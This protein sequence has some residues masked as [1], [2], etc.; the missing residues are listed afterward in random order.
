MCGIAG[1]AG[2]GA[3]A[4]SAQLGDM[5][6]ALARRGPDGEGAHGW[7]DALLGHRRLAIFDLTDAGR[8]PMLSPDGR[9]GVTFNGAIYNFPQLRAQLIERGYTFTSRTDTEVLVHG[10]DAWGIDALVDRLHGMFA[11]ALWDDRSRTLHLVRDRLGVK[12]LLYTQTGQ[13]LAFA[14]TATA[15]AA[16]RLATDLDAQGIAEFLEFSFVSDEHS[17]YHNVKKLPAAH[18]A[19]WSDGVLSLRKYWTPSAHQDSDA[20][21]EEAVQETEKIFLRAVQLRLEADVPVAAL[22]SGGIDSSLVCWGIKALG[23]DVTAYTIATPADPWDESGDAIQTAR[24]IGIAH[25]VLPLS[26]ENAPEIGDL[27]CAYGEPFACGSALG[28]LAISKLVREHAKVLLT[29]DGG[30]DVFLGYPRD[31][32]YYFAQRMAG[33]LPPQTAALWTSLRRALPG[34]G[35]LR[36]AMHFLDYATGGYPAV[37]A[38]REGLPFY[39]EHGMLGERLRD[40]QLPHRLLAPS[41]Q[42]ARRIMADHLDFEMRTSF[43]SEYMAK[44]DG[45][46]MYHALE[47]RSPMLDQR[48]WEY[49]SSLPYGVRLRGGKLKAV[50]REIAR[51]R[52]GERVAQGAKRGFGVPVQRWLTTRWR[53]DFEVVFAD[54]VLEK[55]GWIDA[56]PVL[57]AMRALSEGDTAPDQLWYLYVLE[58]WMRGQSRAQQARATESA[59]AA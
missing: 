45:G 16:A 15:L 26:P 24:E 5:L 18:V 28:T 9:I 44:V 10:Y 31:R 42:A 13:Q 19:T 4:R 2:P 21:F 27:V 57:C 12:P 1:I 8:Q 7:Q 32:N 14:S 58:H 48:L 46:T 41:P 47:A 34:G 23:A 59:P 55:H 40:V 43:V 51:R 6:Q 11:F 22:L 35:K 20:S 37:I 25:R 29:G 54:S 33:V 30:D 53:A 39:A 56:R 52:I 36:R 38:V 49:A 50:L 3:C 17:V